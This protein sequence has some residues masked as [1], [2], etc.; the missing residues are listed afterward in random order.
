[1]SGA[2]RTQADASLDVGK[3]EMVCEAGCAT[4]RL[5]PRAAAQLVWVC[6]NVREVY[7]DSETAADVAADLRGLA[8]ARGL[9]ALELGFSIEKNEAQAAAEIAA[10]LTAL[11][12]L[13]RLEL[14]VAMPIFKVIGP[15]PEGWEAGL[16]SAMRQLLPQALLALT[17]LTS[18][19]L[20]WGKWTCTL[21]LGACPDS[22][23]E[24]TLAD[25]KD[26][27]MYPLK[28]LREVQ[29]LAGVTRLE[30]NG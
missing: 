27:Y 8:A 16:R 15:R 18:L 28:I 6:P 4:L 5:S 7:L 29:P 21:P 13:R 19:A 10:A 12:G 2:G 17:R 14:Y 23:L 26:T 11:G 25:G 20:S 24:L 22:L 1:M 9:Q 30:L 3:P